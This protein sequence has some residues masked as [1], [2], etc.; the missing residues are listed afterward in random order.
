[1]T[2]SQGEGP[3]NK[4]VKRNKHQNMR[5][6][7]KK[8]RNTTT[9]EEPAKTTGEEPKTTEPEPVTT[10]EKEPEEQ[11]S[12]V[13]FPRMHAWVALTVSSIVCLIAIAQKTKSEVELWVLI[14]S[15]VSVIFSFLTSVVY[16]I[17]RIADKFV[18]KMYEGI[19][20]LLV[21]LFWIG[22]FQRQDDAAAC[23]YSL[24]LLHFQQRGCPYGRS[25]CVFCRCCC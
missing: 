12:H 18:D 15:C 7:W 22:R 21:L 19:I 25:L 2:I 1:M 9:D 8:E 3:T 14:V 6:F 13:R 23:S 4:H 11:A 17:R 16:C 5:K 10:E 20:A 24:Y